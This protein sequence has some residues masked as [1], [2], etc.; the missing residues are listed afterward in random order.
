MSKRDISS[1]LEDLTLNSLMTVSASQIFKER[2]MIFSGYLKMFTTFSG[3]CL[4]LEKQMPLH[5]SFLHAFEKNFLSNVPII[6][7]KPK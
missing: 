5:C 7:T 3:Y 4:M 1:K 2:K 6:L